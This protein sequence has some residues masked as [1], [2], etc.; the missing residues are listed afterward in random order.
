MN[1]H[2][3]VCIALLAAWM[4]LVNTNA[5]A[6]LLTGFVKREVF[7]NLPGATV[8]DLTG[9]AKFTGNQPDGVSLLGSFEAPRICGNEYGQRIS[10]WLVPP[11]NGTYVFFIASDN[12][13][14]LWLSTD[15]NSAN[16]QLIASVTGNT[17]S[18]EW[19]KYPDTQN[20]AAAPIVLQA[21]QRYYI[22]ALMKED[23]GADSLAVGWVLPG[24]T[25][26]P[27]ADPPVGLENIV[28]IPGSALGAM[29]EVNNSSVTIATGPANA[30]SSVGGHAGFSV[31]ATGGS[32][33]GPYL[34]YQWKRNGTDIAGANAASYIT[35][36]LTVGDDGG[37]YSCVASVPGK[38]VASA[39]ARLT[40]QAQAGQTPPVRISADPPGPNVSVTWDS[41]DTG[42]SLESAGFLGG[43]ASWTGVSEQPTYVGNVASVE[44]A[45][46]D[47]RQF[48]RLKSGAVLAGAAEAL[49]PA[50]SA[51]NADANGTP[52]QEL[53]TIFSSKV[54]GVIRAVRVY[55]FGGETGKRV[56]R[57]WRNSDNTVLAGP[58]DVPCPGTTG[59]IELDLPQ[60]LSIE[61]DVAYTVSVSTANDPANVYPVSANF[62]AAAG[63]NDKSLTFPAGAG[64]FTMQLGTRPTQTSNNSFYFRDVLFVPGSVPP[65]NVIIWALDLPVRLGRGGDTL[66]HELGTVFRSSVAGT[67]T[68]IR[69]LS[70]K[71][72][73]GDH[74]AAIWRNSDDAAIGGPYTFPLG[75]NGGLCGDEWV[76]YPLDPP[77]AIQ[78]NTEYTV[79]VSTGADANRAYPFLNQAFGFASGNGEHLTYP[80][81]AGVIG[82]VLGVR[83][84]QSTNSNPSYLRDVV[85]QPAQ[86][87]V[88]ES[89]TDG[90]A[91]YP[92]KL[93]APNELGTIFQASVA[94]TITAVR[95]YSLKVESGVHKARIWKNSDNTLIGGPYDLTY[96][97][98]TG[99][100]IFPLPAAVTIDQ[101]VLYTIAVSTGDD[102]DKAYPF[103]PDGFISADNNTKHLSYPAMAGVLTTTLGTR[104]TQAP[105][106][107]SYLRDI[108][109]QPTAAG[110]SITIGNTTDATQ[111]DVITN[112]T[113][114]D[115]TGTNGSGAYIN[116][117]RFQVTANATL[118][119]IKVKIG[120]A[121]GEYKC[122]IYSDSGG[123]ADRLLAQSQ[124]KSNPTTGWN[125]FPL[126]APLKVKA[127]DLIWL[128]I[129]SND[130]SATVYFSVGPGRLRWGAYPYA[131]TWP[132]PIMMEANGNDNAA[133]CIYAEGTLDVPKP[134]TIG[135][136]TDAT[137]A[138]VITNPTPGDTT[139]TNGSGAY[140]NGNQFQVT[141]NG[142]LTNVTLTKIKAK[143]GNAPGEYKCAIYSDSNGL[144]DRL[145][146]QTQPKSNPAT[147]W[148]EFPLL[149]PLRL[150]AGDKIW[151]VIWSNDQ[152][153][154]VYYSV[155]PGRL[156]WGATPYGPVW[157][158]P[159]VM[160][161]N[162]NDN[163]AYCIYAEGTFD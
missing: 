104:P 131:V 81:G 128:V 146:A 80:L 147:G 136:T 133:Y 139:G 98:T 94:G 140:I 33:L 75:C 84:T 5:A 82:D 119:K 59:W 86:S 16:K 155:G 21:G 99:W 12:D 150:K 3:T 60:A 30:M 18:R 45:A 17:A 7:Y 95:V 4:G 132:D 88:G 158:D 130:Q 112:P 72:E 114:G 2:C 70:T 34:L 37:R 153:A 31:Q 83:P 42:I 25:V 144:G 151:L 44:L 78:A 66:D 77:V 89:L 39:E 122:A 8:A 41:A 10:G 138:D 162:G 9:N 148:N 57:I 50:T 108:V 111:A 35:P 142:T 117:N 62:F 38:S 43:A 92:G 23:A 87:T 54:P 154:T 135:N 163:A 100:R 52:G 161:P 74:T 129:W 121:P 71:Q 134:T 145:L 124:P 157:P 68:A 19:N 53:G 64:V 15:S 97:G 101:N 127:G 24:Q 1:K 126:L 73:G 79:S 115:P 47:P 22:E 27:F 56:A 26:D 46:T 90:G 141:P 96:G 65:E 93:S 13:S 105:N 103:V 110:S 28:V 32:D 91:V 14:E 48:F 67:I 118:T 106:G 125:E 20:N 51:P 36:E 149:A 58:F 116:G 123:L 109:F 160:E 6:Q 152:S 156:R 40:V 76:I 11:S 137:Q 29:V 61:A 107:K 63:G 49:F 143:I 120:N 55:S 159:I 85:F 69:V 102:P 113:A